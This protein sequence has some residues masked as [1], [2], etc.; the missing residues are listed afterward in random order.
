MRHPQNRIKPTV[1]IG[2]ENGRTL[3]YRIADHP[4]LDYGYAVTS[5]SA[6][7]QTADR[8]LVHVDTERAGAHQRFT[9]VSVSRGRYEA[10]VYTDD[11]TRIVPQLSRDVSIAQ[12]SSRKR[13]SHDEDP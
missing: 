7:G 5:H 8:V 4:H 1:A 9:Y 12:R 13:H 11:A 3:S 10:K 6:Q 2:L